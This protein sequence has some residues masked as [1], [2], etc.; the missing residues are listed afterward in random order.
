MTCCCLQLPL[1]CFVIDWQLLSKRQ[2]SLLVVR[3]LRA[4]GSIGIDTTTVVE[5]PGLPDITP[6]H[7]FRKLKR[8]LDFHSPVSIG[9]LVAVCSCGYSVA[10]FHLIGRWVAFQPV[11]DLGRVPAAGPQPLEAPFPRHPLNA[12]D[13]RGAPEPLGLE[14]INP[15]DGHGEICHLEVIEGRFFSCVVK[16]GLDQRLLV[17]QHTPAI[18]AFPSAGF[19]QH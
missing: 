6:G 19:D 5:I 2:L 9:L 11:G 10:S 7:V 15:S 12:D 4:L 3:P 17:I 13:F 16:D 1:E 14:R 18:E 8:A